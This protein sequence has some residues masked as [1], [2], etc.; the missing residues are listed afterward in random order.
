MHKYGLDQVGVI[1]YASGARPTSK[2][3]AVCLSV[4]VSNNFLR[5]AQISSCQDK[6]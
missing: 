6:K 4:P 1:Q 3:T 2:A 5:H